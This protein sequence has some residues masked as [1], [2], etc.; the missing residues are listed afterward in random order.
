MLALSTVRL[1]GSTQSA[2]GEGGGGGDSTGTYVPIGGTL[3]YSSDTPPA[4]YMICNG[5]S[6]STTLY[7][8]LYTAIGKT[9]QYNKPFVP[10]YFYLPDMQGIFVRS[11]FYNEV[12]GITGFNT[13]GTLDEQGLIDHSHTFQMAQTTILVKREGEG[14]G[15]VHSVW[16]DNN[17]LLYTPTTVY[18]ATGNVLDNE[19]VPYCIALNYIIR[20][21]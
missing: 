15:D 1:L 5:S 8:D 2:S 9:F 21:Q 16:N 4:G 10:G 13:I 7:A 17:T 14:Q 11:C 6:V 12:M 3:M 18:D 19:T 20:Y